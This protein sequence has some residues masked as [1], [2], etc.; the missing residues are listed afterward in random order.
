MKTP[1]DFRDFLAVRSIVEVRFPRAH[2]YWDDCG[3]LIETLETRVNGVTC[4]GL[5][6]KGFNFVGSDSC[7]ILGARFFWDRVLIEQ[8]SGVSPR[9]FLESA[10]E[11][12]RLSALGLG[13]GHVAGVGHRLWYLLKSEDKKEAE[14]WLQAQRVWS[15]VADLG[16]TPSNDGVVLRAHLTDRSLR[17]E[18]GV[19][20]VLIR[21][22]RKLTGVLM[23]TDFT[24]RKKQPVDS[25]DLDVFGNE[26]LTWLKHRLH[27]VIQQ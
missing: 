8:Q 26:N 17:L 10:E 22:D 1:K 24:S 16:G 15:S 5:D 9:K 4:A 6:A 2:K 21:Q 7:P 13:V 20:D 14:D 11:F 3:K 19:A 25:L 12:W 27:Q 18:I 23:D